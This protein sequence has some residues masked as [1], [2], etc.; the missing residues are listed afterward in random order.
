MRATAICLK[1]SSQYLLVELKNLSKSQYLY[2][3]KGLQISTET[4][5]TCGR[6]ANHWTATFG[7]IN[8]T[9][10]L[11]A[12][13]DVWIW[14][15]RN[16]LHNVAHFMGIVRAVKTGKA[17]REE[18][19]RKIKKY[20]QKVIWKRHEETSV[21]SPMRRREN[22]F[23]IIYFHITEDQDIIWLTISRIKPAVSTTKGFEIVNV[24]I[25]R[26]LT[27]STTSSFMAVFSEPC[28]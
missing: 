12:K 18:R 23:Q 26:L 16:K 13:K 24:D 17:K 1:L 5:W 22:I 2:K 4:P 28:Y 10:G 6:N 11:T 15:R 14:D 27:M 3:A 25:S 21:R 19:K 9:W 7:E 8:N 20:V